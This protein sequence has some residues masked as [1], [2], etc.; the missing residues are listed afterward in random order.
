V[1]GSICKVSATSF[2]TIPVANAALDPIGIVGTI[3]GTVI[4]A[5]SSVALETT[6]MAGSTRCC[7]IRD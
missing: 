5:G 1:S 4:T 6:T 7:Y 3:S 2:I